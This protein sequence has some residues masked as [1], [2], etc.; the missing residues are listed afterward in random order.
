MEIKDERQSNLGTSFN[1]FELDKLEAALL[2]IHS[3]Q[4]FF[5]KL[6]DNNNRIGNN[7]RDYF[8]G[9]F[10]GTIYIIP[11]D[12]FG[13]YL[14]TIQVLSFP[15]VCGACI[16]SLPSW[17]GYSLTN[18]LMNEFL[19]L[20]IDFLFKECGYGQIMFTSNNDTTTKL[21][22]DSGFEEVTNFLNPRTDTVIKMLI[23]NK[24]R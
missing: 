22:I 6:V 18:G 4:K 21:F 10:T 24:K 8:T 23:Y 13:S 3:N 11:E 5:I 9:Y 19:K 20:L 16:L 15:S 1:K 17:D 2:K 14:V 12:P 7:Y